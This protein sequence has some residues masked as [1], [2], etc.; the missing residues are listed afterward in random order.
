MELTISKTVCLPDW[1][2]Q[3]IDQKVLYI[4]DEDKMQ[5]AI[6]LA[7]LNVTNG[8]GGPFGAAIFENEKGVLVSVG[9]NRVVLEKCSVAHAEIVAIMMAQSSLGRYRLDDQKYVL[10]SSSQPC[11]M[12]FGALIW[13]G[14]DKLIFGAMK[15]DVDRL[16][17]FDEGPLPP[18]WI[19]ELEIRNIKVVP[20]VLQRRA[21]Q[22]LKLYKNQGGVVY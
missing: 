1:I 15:K 4:T 5:L 10:A 7:R 12:C 20:G 17:G 11:S 18:D 2:N 16:A 13:S 3:E 22:I 9:V 8:T 21:C 6:K 14:V 19:G